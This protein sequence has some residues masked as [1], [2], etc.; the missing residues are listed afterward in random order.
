MVQKD[1]TYRGKT[2]EEIKAMSLQDFAQLIPSR[3]RRTLAKGFTEAQKRF[4]AKVKKAKETQR[5]KP[6]RTH[7]RDMVVIPELVGMTL[8]IHRGK[9][10][11]TIEITE[12]MLGHALG[13]FAHT[14]NSVKHNAPGVGA[15]KSSASASVK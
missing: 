3:A 7:C 9:E 12:E 1:F 14:R 8:M 10:W 4:L 11:A 15:T 6:L 2:F 5:K 13:E